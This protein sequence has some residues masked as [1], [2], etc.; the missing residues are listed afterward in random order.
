M[1]DSYWECRDVRPSGVSFCL[2]CSQWDHRSVSV[3]QVNARSSALSA[4]QPFITRPITL[5]SPD[6][7]ISEA[8]CQM[9]A[10]AMPTGWGYNYVCVCVVV[11][12]KRPEWEEFGFEA[13]AACCWQD[14]PSRGDQRSASS[15]ALNTQ[16][17]CSTHKLASLQPLIA[18]ISPSSQSKR[19]LVQAFNGTSLESNISLCL[20]PFKSGKI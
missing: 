10:V 16:Q 14:E 1:L 11:C 8:P 5:G 4:Q 6:D 3:F 18:V 2:S 9:I 17:V 15:S 20:F 13:A 12:D 19:G 7:I